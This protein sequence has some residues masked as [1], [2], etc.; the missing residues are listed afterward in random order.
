MLEAQQ[1]KDKDLQSVKE[2]MASTENV[3]VAI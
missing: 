3:L 1:E 2:R